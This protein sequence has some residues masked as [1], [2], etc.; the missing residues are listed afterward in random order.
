MP[1]RK[2]D[3]Q[4]VKDPILYLK[5]KLNKAKLYKRNLL[6]EHEDEYN[7]LKYHFHKYNKNKHYSERN[8]YLAYKKFKCLSTKI[9][10]F[11]IN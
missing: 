7:S 8:G 2:K 1:I 6:W 5:M 9:R 10:K 4:A 3:I 11:L